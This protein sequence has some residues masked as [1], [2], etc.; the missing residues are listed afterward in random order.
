MKKILLLWLTCFVCIS[1]FSQYKIGPTGLLDT[2]N[3][4]GIDA[5]SINSLLIKNNTAALK[6]FRKELLTRVEQTVNNLE[7]DSLGLRDQYSAFFCHDFF[8]DFYKEMLGIRDSLRKNAPLPGA[9]YF[10][11]TQINQWLD[12]AH[13]YQ[14]VI[15]LPEKSY[16]A[17]IARPFNEFIYSLYRYSDYSDI[18]G[19]KMDMTYKKAWRQM[20][21]YYGLGNHWLDSLSKVNGTIVDCAM[22]KVDA[23]ISQM[24]Q[25]MRDSCDNPSPAS[26][27]CNRYEREV[28]KLIPLMHHVKDP[29]GVI[30]WLW[31]TGGI[32]TMNPI[33][34]TTP[35]QRYPLT[36]KWTRLD[37]NSVKASLAADTDANLADLFTTL[38]LRNDIKLP[39]DSKKPGHVWV[40][41]YYDNKPESYK[42]NKFP[43]LLTKRDSVRVWVYN[44]S[45]KVKFGF[46]HDRKSIPDA[47]AVITGLNAA[48]DQFP[49]SMLGTTIGANFS[50]ILNNI[51]GKNRRVIPPSDRGYNY[52]FQYIIGNEAPDSVIIP[53]RRFTRPSMSYIQRLRKKITKE[54]GEEYQD[55]LVIGNQRIL[56]KREQDYNLD[57]KNILLASQTF[58]D[59]DCAFCKDTVLHA[60]IDSFVVKDYCNSLNYS[61]KTFINDVTAMLRRFERFMDCINNC[62][63]AVS[64]RIGLLAGIQ[65]YLSKYMV[66]VNRSLPPDST[67]LTAI[68]D[69]KADYSTA[70]FQ[71][72]LE[73]STLQHTIKLNRTFKVND[74]DVDSTF[75]NLK[76]KTGKLHYFD[77]SAGLSYTVTD[78]TVPVSQSNGLP[79]TKTGDQLQL[80]AGL[81]IYPWGYVKV[82]DRVFATKPMSALHRFSLYVGLAISS[83]PLD[84]IYTGIGYDIVPGIK[85]ITGVHWFKN[86]RYQ[87]INNQVFNQA[88]GYEPTWFVGLNIEPLTL[89][90][91]LG[92]IK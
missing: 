16:K 10:P 60:V 72:G 1:S 15:N 71:E 62:K 45:S 32:Y 9:V 11:V 40:N 92:I 14:L 66:I 43:K 52:A 7:D 58:M 46:G 29:N 67:G 65:Q 2:A 76:F 59:P 35:N 41:E 91:I 54:D 79:T 51:N 42:A 73:D 31:F 64:V 80:Q 78:Y 85:P 74:K 25:L 21:Y 87:I 48:L 23:F 69:Q 3:T 6:A 89:T 37:T 75:R 55:V 77:A 5:S 17:Y 8:C 13:L 88:D 36:E 44:V 27:I 19:W 56:L 22:P 18:Q 68:T 38:R 86:T 26:P 20:E 83:K 47:G 57:K 81:H 4:S 34:A 50:S 33:L 90:K 53:A 28:Q 12:T 24:L 30:K 82:D 61:K 63:T 39:P 70:C 49:T 84:H